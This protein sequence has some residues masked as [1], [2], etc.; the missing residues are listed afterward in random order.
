MR[1]DTGFCILDPNNCLHLRLIHSFTAA[2]LLIANT[3]SEIWTV[4]WYRTREQVVHSQE[5]AISQVGTT[6]GISSTNQ[7]AEH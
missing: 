6:P 3:I 7:H 1:L 2:G 4:I 5:H